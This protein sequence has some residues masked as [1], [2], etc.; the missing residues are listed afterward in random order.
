MGVEETKVY[1]DPKVQLIAKKSTFIV[2]V[3]WGEILLLRPG[4]IFVRIAPNMTPV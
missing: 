1:I 2:F 4:A 3:P